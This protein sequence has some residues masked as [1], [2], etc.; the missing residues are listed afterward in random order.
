M[1]DLDALEKRI[2]YS[3]E[4]KELLREAMTHSSKGDI[5]ESG[6]RFDNERL[7]FIGDAMLDAVVGV[8]LYLSLP[9]GSEGELTK[10]RAQ[11]VCEES[12]NRIGNEL[13]FGKFLIIGDSEERSLGRHKPSVIADSVEAVIGG[14]FMD[15]GYGAVRRFVERSF[16]ELI[17][18]ALAG[19]L[20][21]DYKTKLQELAHKNNW[22]VAYIAEDEGPDHDKTFFVHLRVNGAE[23]GYGIG[24][25][26]KEAEQKAAESFF[27]KGIENVL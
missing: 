26:K 23:K 6:I 8:M 27:E 10:L 24:K 22:K 15:G 18:E 12:L 11:I 13:G 21:R 5:R 2:G 20:F 17:E 4:N 25:N 3:F 1:I 19:K 16:G 14:M 7:E 9:N